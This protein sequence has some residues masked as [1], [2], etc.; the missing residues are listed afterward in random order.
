MFFTEQ[1]LVAISDKVE[2]KLVIHCILLAGILRSSSS[3]SLNASIINAFIGHLSAGMF[4]TEYE[5][6]INLMSMN[7]FAKSAGCLAADQDAC[8]LVAITLFLMDTSIN[9]LIASI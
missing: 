1:A 5:H 7:T 6:N 4:L 2:M 8:C 9:D 3:C